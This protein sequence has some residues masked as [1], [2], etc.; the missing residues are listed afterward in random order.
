MAFDKFP[1]AHNF[2]GDFKDP[3]AAKIQARVGS[4]P[5]T[6]KVGAGK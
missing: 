1:D 3:D 2:Y 5:A 4:Q 6:G